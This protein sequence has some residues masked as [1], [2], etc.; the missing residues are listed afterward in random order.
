MEI[1][2]AFVRYWSYLIKNFHYD[3]LA[4]DLS[5]ALQEADTSETHLV[6]FSGVSACLFVQNYEN[7]YQQSSYH[8][9]SEIHFRK[10]CINPKSIQQKWLKCYSIDFNVVLGDVCGYIL[11]KAEKVELDSASYDLCSY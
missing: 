3:A 4:G 2:E 1:N 5:F 7:I 9:M 6:A 11:I 10:E 8:E